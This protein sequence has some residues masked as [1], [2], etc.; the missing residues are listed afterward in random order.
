LLA[1]SQSA[2]DDTRRGD[3]ALLAETALPME[4]MLRGELQ[5]DVVVDDQAP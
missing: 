1:G 3:R 5:L 4:A 2:A